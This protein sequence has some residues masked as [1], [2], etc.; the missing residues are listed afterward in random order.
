[1]MK[2]ETFPV[3]LTLIGSRDRLELYTTSVT[4]AEIL[5]DVL[6]LPAGRRRRAVEVAAEAMFQVDFAGRILSFDSRATRPYADLVTERR[7]R[8]RPVSHFDA[9]IA[10]ITRAASAT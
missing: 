4:Q 2:P 5:D 1:M 6:Q 3:V 9:Q 7:R 8:G 10:A